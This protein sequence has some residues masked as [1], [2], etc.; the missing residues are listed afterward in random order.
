V[1]LESNV[2]FLVFAHHQDVLNSLEDHVRSAKVPYIRICGKTCPKERHALTETFQRDDKTRV[3][4]LSI[5]ACG[6]GL[7]LTAATDV[8]FA[9]LSFT[10]GDLHQAEARLNL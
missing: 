5:K 2:K 1:L 7:T 3:A 9:E 10:P 8:V 6:A 4:I